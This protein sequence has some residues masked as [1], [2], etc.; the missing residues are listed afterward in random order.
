[1]KKRH[2][3]QRAEKKE[4]YSTRE[5]AKELG[6]SRVTLERWVLADKVRAS[7]EIQFD[8]GQRHWR[9]T[10][11]DLKRVLIYK[12]MHYREGRGRKKLSSPGSERPQ[13]IPTWTGARL[14]S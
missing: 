2:T 4:T 6:I 13:R 14:G 1:M 3:K 7:K 9:W 11:W 5:A 12:V 10:K 8:A